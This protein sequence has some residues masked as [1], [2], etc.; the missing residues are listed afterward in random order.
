M[1]GTS[2]RR[3]TSSKWLSIPL[4]CAIDHHISDGCE[5]YQSLYENSPPYFLIHSV[6]FMCYYHAVNG[7]KWVCHSC[8]DQYKVSASSLLWRHNGRDGVSNHQPHDCLLNRLFRRKSKKTSKLRGTGL[9][10]D[11]LPVTNEFPAQRA[12]NEENVS[13]LWCHHAMGFLGAINGCKHVNN[14]RSVTQR[15]VVVYIG[16][17]QPRP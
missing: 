6:C 10:E 2:E 13:I 12:S 5:A 4:V 15:I 7:D 3:D 16:A 17:W 8:L 14:L 9:C 11:N 1:C